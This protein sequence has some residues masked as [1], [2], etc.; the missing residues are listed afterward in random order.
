MTT[1]L[2]DF[3]NSLSVRTPSPGPIS[4]IK[5][6]FSI[7]EDSIIFSITQSSIKSFV[8]SFCL[9]DFICI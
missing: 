6:S 1:T 4:I 9:L 7:F 5:S 3:F 2:F 8:L